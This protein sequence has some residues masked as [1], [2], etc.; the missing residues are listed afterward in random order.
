MKSAEA[1][2]QLRHPRCGKTLP[3]IAQTKYDLIRRA[4]LAVLPRREPGLPFAELPDRV[5]ARLSPAQRRAIG[6]I[7]WYTVS[8]KLH[9]EGL[10][11]I[12]RVAGSTPQRLVRVR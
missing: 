2:V 12:R 5:S 4:I 11:E 3:R 7:A 6:S 8:V 9:I 10:G 1:K